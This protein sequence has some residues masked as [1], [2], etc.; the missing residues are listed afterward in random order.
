MKRVYNTRRWRRLR[1]LILERDRRRCT[2]CGGSGRLEVHHVRPVA[3]GGDP[4]DADNLRTLC[5]RCHFE[6]EP[7]RQSAGVAWRRSLDYGS[8]R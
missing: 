6:A 8:G 1:L 5:R 7:V 2:R 4:F 3:R